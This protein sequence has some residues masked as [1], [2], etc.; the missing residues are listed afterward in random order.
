MDRD[1]VHRIVILV[2]SLTMI[3]LYAGHAIA[4]DKTHE[5]R[6]SI[7]ESPLT[8]FQATISKA[9]GQRCPMY[10]SCSHYAAQAIERHGLIMGWLLIGDRLLRC[11][12]SETRLASK[13]SIRG[14]LRTYD[15]LDANTYWWQRP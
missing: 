12:H 14:S 13:V 6:R 15:P 7:W 1:V 11:G 4:E 2:V 9:D 5:K 3:P 10:P 8:L